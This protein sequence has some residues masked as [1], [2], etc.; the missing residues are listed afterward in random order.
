MI[1][2]VLENLAQ[3]FP[4]AAGFE[5]VAQFL[6]RQELDLLT[7]GRHEIDGERAYAVVARN[8]G[9]SRDSARLEVH[10]RYID[11]QI[12]LAGLDNIGWKSVAH[13]NQPDGPYI[14]ERDVRFYL[15]EPEIWLPLTPG[16]F[17]LFFPEDAHLPS[18]SS[19]PLD[20]LV[21]KVAVD[22]QS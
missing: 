10:R 1:L 15:D 5:K 4:L 3:Y 13:C 18:I 14:E 17:A 12:V 9:R 2:D 19:G 22:G 8:T 21:V 11:L 20:K 6:A 16:R 7:A